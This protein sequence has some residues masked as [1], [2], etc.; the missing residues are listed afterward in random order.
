MSL[1]TARQKN[2]SLVGLYTTA[3]GKFGR[4]LMSVESRK[5]VGGLNSV[6][7]HFCPQK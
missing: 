6:V 2:V 1:Q 3:R 7:D 5:L 4:R